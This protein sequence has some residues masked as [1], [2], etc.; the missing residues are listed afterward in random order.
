LPHCRCHVLGC[1]SLRDLLRAGCGWERCS[2]PGLFAVH[3]HMGFAAFGDSV[4]VVMV[5]AGLG[6]MMFT[7]SSLKSIISRS[8]WAR[9]VCVTR[10]PLHCYWAAPQWRYI[11]E[12]GG[13]RPRVR[14][15]P[16]SGMTWQQALRSFPFWI[17]LPSSRELDQYDGAITHLSGGC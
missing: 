7:P 4:G 3:F 9:S 14:S 10:P 2:A 15:Y 16:P 1:G 13:R 8:G 5:G 6:A 17:S 12:R 11:R